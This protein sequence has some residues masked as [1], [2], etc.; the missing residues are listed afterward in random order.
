MK[1]HLLLSFFCLSL[2]M[3]SCTYVEGDPIADTEEDTP[4]VVIGTYPDVDEALWPYF[5]RFEAEARLRGIEVDL[6]GN[7]ITG[8][9]LELPEDHVAGQC[10][11]NSHAPNH[12]VIDRTFW[13]AASDR[14]REF[15]VFHEL[16]HCELLRDHRETAN[17]NGI[18]V[19]LMRSGAGDCIDN[20]NP[21]TRPFY[22]DE[23]FDPVFRG[24]LLGN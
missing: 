6:I 16:G 10:S 24:D 18:C 21:N 23:L 2:L 3:P 12:V 1:L 14:F 22:L 19:S 8:A 5:S 20:F 9:I 15:V 13:E 7:Q 17:S 11:Y 4:V